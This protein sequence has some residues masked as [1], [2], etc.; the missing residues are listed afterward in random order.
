M[1]GV[2]TGRRDGMERGGIPYPLLGSNGE[3]NGGRE[4]RRVGAMARYSVVLLDADGTLFDYARAEAWAFGAACEKLGL[5][6]E[7]ERDLAAYRR[8]NEEMWGAFERGE[9]DADALAVER[10]ARL[11]EA[12][13]QAGAVEP[14]ALADCYL[15]Y[16]GEGR[17]LI[18]GA[19]DVVARLAGIARIGVITNGLSRVQRSRFRGSGLEEYVEHVAI[20]DEGGSQKPEAAIFDAAL[21]PFGGGARREVVIVGDS[22]SSDIAGGVRYGIATCWYNPEGRE[23]RDGPVPTYEVR[24]LEEVPAIVAGEG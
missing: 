13:G 15:G 21:A 3:L 19:R 14:R 20:S 1:A 12:M 24:R 7:A 4:A 10:F 18:P 6:Y 9:I 5:A 11:L 23:N 16:L 17:F 2:A 8:I 22:L